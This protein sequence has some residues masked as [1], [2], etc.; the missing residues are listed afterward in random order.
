M[1][2]DVEIGMRYRR[3]GIVYLTP[4]FDGF[5]ALP[6]LLM[7]IDDLEESFDEKDRI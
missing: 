1:A 2:L 4:Q 3:C 5:I 7:D 6:V